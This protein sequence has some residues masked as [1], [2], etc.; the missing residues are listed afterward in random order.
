MRLASGPKTLHGRCV[1]VATVCLTTVTGTWDRRMTSLETEAEK[2]FAT[3][4]LSAPR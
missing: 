1:E 3:A 4:F 2:N